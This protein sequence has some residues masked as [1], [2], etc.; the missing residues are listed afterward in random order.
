MYAAPSLAQS[1]KQEIATLCF[2]INFVPEDNEKTMRSICQEV[3]NASSPTSDA[4][5]KRT[6]S[7]CYAVGMG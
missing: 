4:A 3:A 7:A 5:R 1:A 2:R 6:A